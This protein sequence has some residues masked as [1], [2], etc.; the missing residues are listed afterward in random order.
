M[1]HAHVSHV[2]D[3]Q[4][5]DAPYQILIG[6]SLLD[7]A[8]QLVDIPAESNKG[9]L[10]TS[11]NIYDLYGDQVKR[12]L[13]SAGL[14]IHVALV[15]DGEKAKSLS[16][17]S[18]CWDFFGS[19]FLG[20][21]DV[22]F[23]LGGGVVGDLTGFAA[24]SWNRGIFFV[25]LATT[26]VAQVDAAIGGKT[27]IN[28]PSGKNLVGAFHQPLAVVND[29]D[30]LR[31]LPEREFRAG[32]AEVVKYGFI[33]DPT[34]LELLA[35]KTASAVQQDR[36]LLLE[37]VFRSASIKA[38]VV[39]R[40]E[41]ETGGRE[42]LNYGHTLGHALE[43]LSQYRG[44]LHGEA[45]SIGMVFAARLGEALGISDPHLEDRTVSVLSSLGLPTAAQEP[46]SL[47]EIWPVMRRDKKALG[48]VRFVLCPHAG[49]AILVDPPD[50][51]KVQ[52]VVRLFGAND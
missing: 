43:T 3:V 4:V 44:Y 6:S 34:I 49:S 48:G 17:I 36:D 37:L 7:R 46:F 42:L 51:A 15:P 11:R 25:Q 50:A 12:S 13:E 22:L 38:D 40:D 29:I 35:G 10:V 47:A 21:R 30:T 41:R 31:T 32:L 28:L 5:R 23:A 18:D 14:D 8:G 16:T 19:I 26:V 24:A 2:V 52:E 27:G 45:V 20:R 1:E 9:V 39:G 33:A